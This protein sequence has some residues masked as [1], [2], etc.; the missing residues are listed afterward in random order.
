MNLFYNRINIY[1]ET[2]Q[3]ANQYYK[4]IA[5]SIK[6]SNIQL[7]NGNTL[8]KPIVTVVR[9]DTID[10]YL[11][12]LKDGYYPVLLNMANPSMPGGGVTQGASAQE[13]N[14]FRRTNYFMTLIMS[15]YPILDSDTVYSKDVILFR[16]NE[17]TGYIPI[18]PILINIIACP[19][20]MDPKLDQDGLMKESKDTELQYSKI[21]MILKTAIYHNH[22]SIVLS[23]FGCGAFRC[24]SEQ[25]AN[26]FKKAIGEY[27]HYFKKIIFA[28]KQPVDDQ[29]KNNYQLFYN[30][31]H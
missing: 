7:I 15:F 28:I 5:Q 12:L 25:V 20:I 9:N 18:D 29:S 24:P 4:N 22:D 10:E 8:N 30:T 14:I 17:Q 19:S 31:F 11:N 3:I 21:C 1:K 16:S 27:G 13:E 2:Q 6:H 26:L 23:A